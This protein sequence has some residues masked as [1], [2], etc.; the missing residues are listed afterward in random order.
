[1]NPGE[2][3]ALARF[4]A[5]RLDERADEILTEWTNRL[6]SRTENPTID[7]PTY[8]AL[9]DHIAPVLKAV[10]RHLLNPSVSMCEE[11]LGQLK[12][13]GQIRHDQGYAATDLVLEFD[14]LSDLVFRTM[15]DE[16]ERPCEPYPPGETLEVLGR[17]ADGL[18]AMSNIVLAA[19]HQTAED[20]RHAMALRLAYFGRAIGHELRNSLNT[21]AIG[22]QLLHNFDAVKASAVGAQQLAAIEAAVKRAGGLIDDVDMLSLAQGGDSRPTMVALPNLLADLRMDIEAQARVSDVTLFWPESIPQVAVEGQSATLALVNVCTNA[23]KY[24]DA[25]KG[26]RWVDVSVTLAVGDDAPFVKILVSDNGIGIPEDLQPRVFQR[27]FRAHPGYSTGTGLG[28]AITQELLTERGG[29]VE[30][31]SCEGRGT[32]VRM[33]L[34]ARGSASEHGDRGRRHERGSPNGL[35]DANAAG[36][37]DSSARES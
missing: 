15:R 33:V 29:C 21:I 4:V 11:L 37:D 20:R 30:L 7:G 25:D 10:S 8:R 9:G 1:M 31:D 18:R 3:T 26:N 22:I 34:R 32:Q 27:G 16:V 13:L 24:S 35:P 6:R 36:D 2:P 19:N 5:D 23:I 14:E 28:L 12:L 17:L